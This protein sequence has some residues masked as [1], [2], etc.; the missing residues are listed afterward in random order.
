MH[1]RSGQ[2]L[3]GHQDPE[4]ASR[5]QPKEVEPARLEI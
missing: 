4:I 1:L 2:Y 5:Y 3:S